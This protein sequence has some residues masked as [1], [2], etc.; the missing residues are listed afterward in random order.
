MDVYL[1]LLHCCYSI[2]ECTGE[3]AGTWMTYQ[4]LLWS[5]L[6][7]LLG[8]LHY[9]LLESLLDV[10][11]TV[12]C[13][14]AV[15]ERCILQEELS[16]PHN[17]FGW[18]ESLS[19]RNDSHECW[20]MESTGL[21]SSSTMIIITDTIIRWWIMCSCFCWPW[22]DWKSSGLHRHHVWFISFDCLVG[23]LFGCTCIYVWITCLFLW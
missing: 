22:W 20:G 7:I 17:A 2:T 11:M 13:L 3:P 4:S 10:C 19:L 12:Q 1:C 18:W 6:D 5:L 15:P 14:R 9:S 16:F 21:S 23:L 8:N